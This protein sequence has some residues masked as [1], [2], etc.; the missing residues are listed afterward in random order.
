MKF[1]LKPNFFKILFLLAVFGMVVLILAAYFFQED[2]VRLSKEFESPSKLAHGQGISFFETHGD[3][4]V[5]R[6]SIDTFSVD[7]AKLGP[8]A[9]GP[10]IVAHLNK[11]NLDLY[12]E[13]IESKLE[14]Q[15]KAKEEGK[16][17]GAIDLEGALANIRKNLPSKVKIIK[18]DGISINLWKEEKRIFSLS[19]DTATFDHKTGDIVFTGHVK[20]DAGEN[21]NLIAYR[22]RWIRETG[23]FKV[24]DPYILTKGGMRTEGREIETDYTLKKIAK[25]VSQK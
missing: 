1:N 23:L 3:Q 2:S 25:S 21:G 6:V 20:M 4:K 13:G 11:I 15:R 10:L 19:S 16:L 22:V 7:R 17:E 18:A 12:L 8:F 5:Y 9:I 14:S 24:I